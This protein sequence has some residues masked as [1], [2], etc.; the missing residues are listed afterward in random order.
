M[1]EE[2]TERLLEAMSQVLVPPF[3]VVQYNRWEPRMDIRRRTLPLGDHIQRGTSDP[4]KRP[5]GNDPDRWSS[6][7]LHASD[8][9]GHDLS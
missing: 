5:N 8:T 7:A 1:K 2:D 6:R 3:Q 4:L 9:K